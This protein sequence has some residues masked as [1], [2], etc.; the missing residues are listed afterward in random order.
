MSAAFFT[1]NHARKK[2]GSRV[3]TD[4]AVNEYQDP[5]IRFATGIGA[6][7]IPKPANHAILRR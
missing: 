6:E 3:S 1:Y 7:A 2:L 5:D 4:T